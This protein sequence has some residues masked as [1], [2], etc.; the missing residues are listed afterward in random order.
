MHVTV[1]AKANCPQCTQTRREMDSLGIAYAVVDLERDSAQRSRLIAA[2]YR[3]APV[4]ES[5]AG[6]W[7]GYQPERI[8]GLIAAAV[9]G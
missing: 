7:S 6:A 5:D 1:Y 2:G 9:A 4:V 8:R 3:T